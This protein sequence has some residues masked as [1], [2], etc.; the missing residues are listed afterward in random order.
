MLAKAANVGDAMD[1]GGD[2]GMVSGDS[3]WD[4]VMI[5]EGE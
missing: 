4:K 1:A 5:D 2:D 3:E